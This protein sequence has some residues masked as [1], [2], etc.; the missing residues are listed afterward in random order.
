MGAAWEG[1]ATGL[2]LCTAVDCGVESGVVVHLEL[3]VKFEAPR[4]CQR[5][6]PQQIEAAG[7]VCAL[8]S[9]DCEAVAVAFA[10]IGGS[11]GSFSLFPGM[12]DLER[13][14]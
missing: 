3:A 5:L 1:S 10:V 12:V 14:Y 7:E 6:A 11:V 13:Q 2:R 8:I 9:E 4:A